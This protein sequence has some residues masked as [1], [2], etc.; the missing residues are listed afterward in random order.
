MQR[1]WSRRE[2]MGM[3]GSAMMSMAGLMTA[4]RVLPEDL[5]HRVMETD[6][7]IPKGA[8][9]E[10]IVRRFGTIDDYEAAPDTMAH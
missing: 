3:R 5:Y 2:V 10:E 7:E 6:D 8:T 9:F 4:L 1:L